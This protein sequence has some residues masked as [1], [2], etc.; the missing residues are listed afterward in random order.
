ML[1]HSLPMK[2]E[3]ELP[4]TYYTL[5][6]NNTTLLMTSQTQN[7]RQKNGSACLFVCFS[8]QLDQ[9]S[10]EKLLWAY[11]CSLSRACGASSVGVPFNVTKTNP[12]TGE[13]GKFVSLEFV[14]VFLQTMFL[15][16][17]AIGDFIF[18]VTKPLIVNR[19]KCTST[20]LH[21]DLWWFLSPRPHPPSVLVMALH[22]RFC[23]DSSPAK[24]VRH[25]FCPTCDGD[26]ASYRSWQRLFWGGDRKISCCSAVH[27]GNGGTRKRLLYSLRLFYE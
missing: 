4:L 10:T 1:V 17:D 27:I 19:F 5:L 9:K 20:A 15:P 11:F 3:K 7:A 22:L 6:L 24:R 8:K 25:S 12:N 21:V 13:L 18:Q 14:L 2:A 23:R 16:S 26:A